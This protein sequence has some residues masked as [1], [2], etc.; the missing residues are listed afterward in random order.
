MNIGFKNTW[1][2]WIPRLGHYDMDKKITTRFKIQPQ[3]R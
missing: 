1:R 3:D 2:Q